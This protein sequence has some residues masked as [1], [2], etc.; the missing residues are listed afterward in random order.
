MTKKEFIEKIKELGWK[1]TEMDDGIE[2]NQY[3]PAGEDFCLFIVGKTV[4]KLINSIKD[5]DFDPEEHA[6]FWYGANRGEPSSL[7]VLLEDAEAI[8]QMLI[9]TKNLFSEEKQFVK[10]NPDT[11]PICGSLLIEHD[12]I[13]M[14]GDQVYYPWH[15][16]RCGATGQ[17]TYELKF[18]GHYNV[19]KEEDK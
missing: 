11:C 10:G 2:I 19:S 9:E 14:A 17:E 3:S 7:R 16:V 13:E 8:E 5:I 6:N 18:I 1:V 4:E 12:E 15:C